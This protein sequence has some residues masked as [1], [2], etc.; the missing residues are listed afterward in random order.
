MAKERTPA[1]RTKGR[2]EESGR[3]SADASPMERFKSLTRRLINVSNA[4]V[5]KAR[6]HRDRKK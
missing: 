1:D 5:Q 6:K 4:E 2:D 3:K